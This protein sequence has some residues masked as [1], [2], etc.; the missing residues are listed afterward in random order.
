MSNFSI[1]LSALKTAEKIENMLAH[2]IANADTPGYKKLVEHNS[3]VLHGSQ[4]GGVTTTIARS[5]NPFLDHRLNMALG[6]AAE[7]EAFDSGVD[8]LNDNVKTKTVEEAFSSFMNASHDLNV[9]PSDTARQATFAEAGKI[10]S[11]QLRA[12]GD[13]FTT[14]TQQIT[15]M[16]DYTQLE[17]NELQNQL[18]KLTAGPVTDESKSAVENLSRQVM[19]KTRSIEGYNKVINGVIPPITSMYTLA[20]DTVVDGS[21]Q[22]YGQDIIDTQGNFNFDPSN[23]GNVKALTEF[24]SQK[25]NKDMGAMNTVMGSKLNAAS[26]ESQLKLDI[27]AGVQADVKEQTGVDLVAET[28]RSKQYQRMYEAASQIIKT[29]DEM[30]GTILNIRG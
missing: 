13:Q 23:V 6:D 16:R 20:R 27:L 14:S 28:L 10:F 30:M 5:G 29:Q 19:M 18:S 8:I 7:A 21:N 1:G 9:N 25:F 22:S 26:S 2:N 4:L 12:L 17:L 11:T 24:G 15:E 3:E